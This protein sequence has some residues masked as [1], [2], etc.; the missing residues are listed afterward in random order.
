[1]T[2]G[3][4]DGVSVIVE[5]GVSDVVGERDGVRDNE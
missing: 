4:L 1:V 5:V 3:V 2:V